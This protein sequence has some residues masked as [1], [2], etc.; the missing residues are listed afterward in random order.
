MHRFG[1]VWNR[2]IK[3]R[4]CCTQ[5]ADYKALRISC[6]LGA[7]SLSTDK[8]KQNRNRT[9]P[10]QR[11]RVRLPENHLFWFLGTATK[12]RKNSPCLPPPSAPSRKQKQNACD[13]CDGGGQANVNRR[14]KARKRPY[15]FSTELRLVPFART[16]PRALC[17][18]CSDLSITAVVV[19]SRAQR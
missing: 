16:T 11:E 5:S 4:R 10:Q 3:G 13:C 8:P 7:N 9:E 2:R 6:R 1:F 19:V 12:K 15:F 17:R 18:D 14:T